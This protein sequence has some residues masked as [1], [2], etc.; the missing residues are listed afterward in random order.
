MKIYS[1]LT[2]TIMHYK[3]LHNVRA[4]S[5]VKVKKKERKEKIYVSQ[6]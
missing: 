6:V 2:H 4:L 3:G 1:A 5:K